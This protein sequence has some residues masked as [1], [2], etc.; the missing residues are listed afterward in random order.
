MNKLLDKM[1]RPGTAEAILLCAMFKQDNGWESAH[2]ELPGEL[3]I[4]PFIDFQ[5]GQ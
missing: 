5:F 4:M 1:G 3:H 2:S